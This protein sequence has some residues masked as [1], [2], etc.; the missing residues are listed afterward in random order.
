MDC[1]K[2]F[3]DKQKTPEA[4]GIMNAVTDVL[5]LGNNLLEKQS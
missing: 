3:K 2:D 1:Y 5:D 4:N